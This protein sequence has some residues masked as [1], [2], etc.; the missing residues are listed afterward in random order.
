MPAL[1]IKEAEELFTEA[2]E[3]PEQAQ[4][5]STTGG[6]IAPSLLSTQPTSEAPTLD[7]QNQLLN[8]WFASRTEGIQQEQAAVVDDDDDGAAVEGMAME[9]VPD[10]QISAADYLAPDDTGGARSDS[11]G[12]GDSSSGSSGGTTQS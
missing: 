12:G 1:D 6:E 11:G 8:L 9:F 4:L 2:S 5:P 10:T 3:H 7:T